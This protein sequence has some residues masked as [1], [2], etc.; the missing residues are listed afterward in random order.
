[1]RKVVIISLIATCSFQSVA[2]KHDPARYSVY[3]KTHRFYD[4]GVYTL[5]STN[6]AKAQGGGIEVLKDVSKRI[7]LGLGYG[8]MQVDSLA[9]GNL[10]TSQAAH[11]QIEGNVG[12]KLLQTK[13]VKPYVFFGYA[14]NHMS[15]LESFDV[16]PYGAYVNFGSRCEIKLTTNLAV[17]YGLTYNFSLSENM[18]YNF[19]HQYGLVFTP[20]LI[21]QSNSNDRRVEEDYQEALAIENQL[22]K[23]QLDSVQHLVDI[24]SELEKSPEENSLLVAYNADLNQKIEQLEQDNQRLLDELRTK[25]FLSD[26]LLLT[27]FSGYTFI[28][29]KGDVISLNVSELKKGYYLSFVNASSLKKAQELMANEHFSSLESVYILNRFDTFLVVGY[30]TEKERVAKKY[31]EK[32]D[33]NKYNYRIFHF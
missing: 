2:Q 15:Q 28:N 8:F 20:R 7:T 1:M 21:K 19:R 12:L 4:P 32:I 6:N 9:Y 5:G 31:L 16:K 3:Y 29:D 26:S 30:L 24:Q 13:R 33:E 18:R 11:H 10:A 25:R 14:Y 23:E 22:L 17:A 27:D